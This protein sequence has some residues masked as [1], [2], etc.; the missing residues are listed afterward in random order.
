MQ[1]VF[2]QA[3]ENDLT[4]IAVYIALDNPER[5][6]SFTAE[7]AARANSLIDMPLRGI[8]RKTLR[9]GL[10]ALLH[11]AYGIYYEIDGETIKV[12]RILH[13]AR[14]VRRKDFA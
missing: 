4:E 5:A 3:A 12:L 8:E 11:G 14:R 2:S 9:R 10:R 13:G 6:F 7:L 1:V